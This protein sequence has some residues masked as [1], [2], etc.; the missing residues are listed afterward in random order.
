MAQEEAVA[1]GSAGTARA[2]ITGEGR[3]RLGRLSLVERPAVLAI[4]ERVANTVPVRRLAPTS[5]TSVARALAAVRIGAAG[6]VAIHASRVA[7]VS[8]SRSSQYGLRGHVAR[9]PHAEQWATSSSGPHPTSSCRSNPASRPSPLP[10][11]VPR[12]SRFGAHRPIS[13]RDSHPEADAQ[14]LEGAPHRSATT[15]LALSSQSTAQASCCEYISRP[16]SDAHAHVPAMLSDVLNTIM[17]LIGDCV[18]IHHQTRAICETESRPCRRRSA[19][20]WHRGRVARPD[21]RPCS[22]SPPKKLYAFQ[23][24]PPWRPARN[25]VARGR[26]RERHRLAAPS[27]SIC[28][29]TRL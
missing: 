6:G 18:T 29:N 4:V 25:T 9:N 5:A 8:C 24:L 12:R 23:R 1:A 7:G 20:P 13:V 22:R 19:A 28:R 11:N 14:R 3:A 26:F 27:S 16:V 2:T 21:I 10:R 15:A 17:L